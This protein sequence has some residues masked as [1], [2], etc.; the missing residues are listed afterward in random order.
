MWEY[1]EFEYHDKNRKMK[2]VI[3]SSRR[4]SS[5][6]EEFTTMFPKLTLSFYAKPSHPGASPS[7]KLI[8]HSGKSLQDC[9]A[10]SKDGV[11][12]ILPTMNI[13]DVKEN[14]RDVYG[15]SVEIFHKGENGSNAIAISD[16]QTLE[17]VN[18]K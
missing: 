15:L 4:I 1:Y 3:N 11:M 18:I 8:R 16:N 2:I 6:Q 9:R 5:I 17:E 7:A 10:I 13:G 12:E 14:F